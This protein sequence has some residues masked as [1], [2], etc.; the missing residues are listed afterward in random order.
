VETGKSC[1]VL[2]YRTNLPNLHG[3][4]DCD[5]NGDSNS[6]NCVHFAEEH[7]FGCASSLRD[8]ADEYSYPSSHEI[9]ST[10]LITSLDLKL[11]C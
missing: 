5:G 10:R 9:F 7:C 4:L 6:N 3:T 8:C 11:I 1:A 2:R